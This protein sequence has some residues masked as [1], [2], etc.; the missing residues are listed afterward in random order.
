MGYVDGPTLG[1]RVRR[2]GAL[3]HQEVARI[4]RDVAWALAYAHAHGVVHC[5]VKPDNILLDRATGRAIVTDF[6]IAQA[7]EVTDDG[8]PRP[9]VGTAH[10]M[11]PEQ[12]AG[13][14]LDGRS[15]I[16]SLGVV[17][18]YALAGQ[19][20]FDGPPSSVLRKHLHEPP[21]S[22]TA[23]NPQ[24]PA[25]LA[26]TVHRALAKS[27]D[28]RFQSAEAFADA[29]ALSIAPQVVASVPLRIWLAGGDEVRYALAGLLG[30]AGLAVSHHGPWSETLAYLT[31]ATAGFLL[32]EI[33]DVRRLL[34]AGYQLHHLRAALRAHLE[35]RSTSDHRYGSD[36]AA[37]TAVQRERRTTIRTLGRVVMAVAV[38]SM[39][40]IA[41]IHR[42]FSSHAL[43][44]A[45]LSIGLLVLGRRSV[46]ES[47]RVTIARTQLWCSRVGS[48]L[49]AIAAW[50]LPKGRSA[51]L[52]AAFLLPEAAEAAQ[53]AWND[54]PQRAVSPHTHPARI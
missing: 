6:G 44:V 32:L 13:R 4:V 46:L 19:L 39:V 47:D 49:A 30:F 18:W 35:Q 28:A 40:G 27:P 8:T 11:S 31:A 17:A 26:E 25:L 53:G 7:G 14:P 42:R 38:I 34:A 33:L 37:A 52:D 50:R 21:P 29:I 3:P 5:D 15:D 45:I 1:A 41:I 10:F 36:R 22:L 43:G 23:V 12:A 24:V 9:V 20:P 48:W 54:A 16:Y 51:V 2:E